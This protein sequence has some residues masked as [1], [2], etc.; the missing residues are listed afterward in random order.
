MFHGV[1][2]GKGA[3]SS[4]E[5]ALL[6]GLVD[7]QQSSMEKAFQGM[8]G[9]QTDALR[10]DGTASPVSPLVEPETQ[11]VKRLQHDIQRS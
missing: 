1:L 7:L 8:G 11:R 4:I 5:L 3:S 9:T 2:L 10:P 6:A